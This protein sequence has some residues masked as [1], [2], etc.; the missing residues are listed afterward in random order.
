MF[1]KNAT[2]SEELNY[3]IGSSA[4]LQIVVQGLSKQ[5]IFNG[6]PDMDRV[7][8]ATIVS[9]LG[10]NMVKYA[11]RGDLRICRSER[12]HAVDVD[13]W[14]EDQGHG[15]EDIERAM[16]DRFSTGGT[17]GLGLPGVKRMAD[18]FWIRSDS[19]K[20]TLVFARKTFRHG[21]LAR[22]AEG[23]APELS[24]APRFES[25]Q[26]GLFGYSVAAHS[27]P[28]NP[29]SGDAACVVSDGRGWLIAMVDASGH[30]QGASLVA[31]RV[32]D[33][34]NQFKGGSLEVVFQRVH[35][36]LKG[37][38]GAAM[39][40]LYLDVTEG[41]MHYA[42]IGNTR[43]AKISRKESWVGIA[44]DG[45]LGNR[46]PSLQV[47]K[48]ALLP[49]DLIVLWTD[50]IADFEGRKLA[51]QHAFKAPSEVASMLLTQLAKPYD[52]AC[53]LVL[54]MF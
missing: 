11:G 46:L 49:G 26:L 8:I 19:L 16:T 39:G 5:K 22:R 24:R 29:F 10:S 43:A 38:A 21:P 48:E 17:L 1:M 37:T 36:D 25:H 12:M 44:R 9:E 47:Q 54:K 35:D 31:R 13:I 42:A 23:T 51:E 28:G 34:L 45:V 33:A 27:Y 50:G 52:D 3:R 32:L 40:L 18:D 7:L 4:D 2:D 53:C 15:I 30:G 41:C 14:A 6:L 20:G